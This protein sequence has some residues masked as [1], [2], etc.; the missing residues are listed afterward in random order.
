MESI[1]IPESVTSIGNYAFA[2]CPSL[3]SVKIQNAECGIDESEY[4]INDTATIYGYS[5]STAQA[6]AKKYD[7]KFVALENQE[8]T[9]PITDPEILWGDADENGKVEILD[10]V[11]MNRVYVGVDKISDSGKKNADTDQDNKIS[12]SDSMNVLKLLVHLLEQN[13]FPIAAEA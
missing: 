3:E 6:Y 4:T 1:T 11:L 5:N 7:R 8:T 10:V 9:D 12:L 13:D 2:Y